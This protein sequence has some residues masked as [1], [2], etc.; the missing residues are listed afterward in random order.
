[1]RGCTVKKARV[2]KIMEEY[3]IAVS[4]YWK[5]R[6]LHQFFLSAAKKQNRSRFFMQPSS[7][8]E[9]VEKDSCILA[10]ILREP[11]ILS[12]GGSGFLS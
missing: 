11:N 3:A 6:S 7:S 12:A 1:M 10:Y 2:H 5:S 9:D 4:E 8:S